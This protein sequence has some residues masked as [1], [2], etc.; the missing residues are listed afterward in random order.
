MKV[1]V[2]TNRRC[3]GIPPRNLRARRLS[4]CGNQHNYTVNG[5]FSSSDDYVCM[6]LVTEVYKVITIYVE[7]SPPTNS[8]SAGYA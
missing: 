7:L 4:S 3:T 6:W 5:I 1:A 2:C 8:L